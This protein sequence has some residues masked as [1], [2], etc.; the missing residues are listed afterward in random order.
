[1]SDTIH[2]VDLDGVV[3]TQGTQN[4]LPGA[5]EGLQ[6]LARTGTIYYFSC[7]AFNVHDMEFLRGLPDVPFA[8][9]IRKPYAAVR[10]TFT[11]DKLDLSDSGV[12]L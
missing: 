8:G 6:R 4:L 10:Y 3:V 5:L 7:W 12:S 9:V 2:L 11:D 1:M